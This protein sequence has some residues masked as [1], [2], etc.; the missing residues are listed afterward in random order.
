MPTSN[1]CKLYLK[2]IRESSCGRKAAQLFT[3]LVHVKMTFRGNYLANKC[4]RLGFV[5][6]IAR[7]A[8]EMGG[9]QRGFS[10]ASCPLQQRLWICKSF[11]FKSSAQAQ[12]FKKKC[13]SSTRDVTIAFVKTRPK[14]QKG[15][16]T[17]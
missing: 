8:L 12:I 14:G 15:I 17:F 16:V 7:H 6:G 10:M 13:K 11:V 1:C 2:D 3:Y 4:M 5:G 9:S